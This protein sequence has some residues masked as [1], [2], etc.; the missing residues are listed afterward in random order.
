M[1]ELSILLG[2]WGRLQAPAY[3]DHFQVGEKAIDILLVDFGSY[4][5]L[6]AVK[7]T[8]SRSPQGVS[9]AYRK[10]L[11]SIYKNA[12]QLLVAGPTDRTLDISEARSDPSSIKPNS[13]CVE[14]LSA[15][16]QVIDRVARLRQHCA[17][18]DQMR[19]RSL[20]LIILNSFT[21]TSDRMEGCPGAPGNSEDGA[22]R[23]DPRRPL[24]RIEAV[25]APKNYQVYDQPKR[26][27]EKKQERSGQ[28]FP[29]S[30]HQGILA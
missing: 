6:N 15:V 5:R 3:R 11:V 25:Q 16:S 9:V 13:L 21:A 18:K 1:R 2:S 27:V 23:L 8:R 22:D 7:S 24:P 29:D 17:N 28:P 30:F 19:F 20:V 10:S 14:I 12:H 4:F 26:K